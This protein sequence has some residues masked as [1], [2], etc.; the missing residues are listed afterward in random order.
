MK[1][2]TIEPKEEFP[3]SSGQNLHRLY[4]ERRDRGNHEKEFQLIRD[5]VY[6]DIKSNPKNNTIT[7]HCNKINGNGDIAHAVLCAKKIKTTFVNFEIIIAIECQP[8][9][10]N[11]VLN[12]FP[13]DDFKFEF[14]STDYFKKETQ[15]ENMVAESACVLGIAAPIGSALLR[16]FPSLKEYGFGNHPDTKGETLSMGFDASSEEGINF[17]IISEHNF[18]ITTPWLNSILSDPQETHLYH[19]YMPASAWTMQII[20]LYSIAQI[21]FK[22]SNQSIDIFMPL[23]YSI[24]KLIE[25][26]ALH[27]NQL[28]QYGIGQIISVSHHNNETIFHSTVLGE[29][30]TLRIINGPVNKLDMEVIEQYAQ[31][32]FGCTGDSSFSA[33]IKRGKVPFYANPGWKK[34]LMLSW[35]SIMNESTEYK[36]LASLV[37]LLIKF[38]KDEFSSYDKHR[39]RKIS[40]YQPDPS[41]SLNDPSSLPRQA[42]PELAPKLVE[43]AT[44]IAKIYLETEIIDEAK[45]FGEYASTNFEINERL[46]SIV[47]RALV[48]KEYPN[49]IEIEKQLELAFCS[50]QMSTEELFMQ[51]KT[52]IESFF[53]LASS[54]GDFEGDRPLLKM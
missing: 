44:Q 53:Q 22:N 48:I 7:L 5:L 32:F 34:N 33:A 47:S 9:E 20:A 27:I 19:M 29:G 54:H 49:A 42:L 3:L 18:K 50:G 2:F 41:M 35:L 11:S 28:Q 24:D 8:H 1:F 43:Y 30:K 46:L 13:A 10:I 39:P 17:P 25:F 6:K 52:S 12:M 40:F 26:R 45:K 21:E 37:E 14:I 4:T 38:E 23:E 51:F 31:P 15:L 16:N 36:A